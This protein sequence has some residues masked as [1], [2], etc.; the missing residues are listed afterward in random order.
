MFRPIL[1]SSSTQLVL[2]KWSLNVSL[3]KPVAIL[4]DLKDSVQRCVEAKA[5]HMI[6][7]K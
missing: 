7:N 1:I 5:S 2:C 4:S 6:D 3:H